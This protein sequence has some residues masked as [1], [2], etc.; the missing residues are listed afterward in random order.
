MWATT[1]PTEELRTRALT[2]RSPLATRHSSLF[3][4]AAAAQ[5]IF[6]V[7]DQP[8]AGRAARRAAE[9]L[10]LVLVVLVLLVVLR[11]QLADERGRLGVLG[12]RLVDLRD[13]GLGL[14]RQFVQ[15]EFEVEQF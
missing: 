10:R 7:L 13:E 4:A 15:V 3:V 8:A 11:L 12:D 5:E 1:G 6:D 2:R 9:R 14:L